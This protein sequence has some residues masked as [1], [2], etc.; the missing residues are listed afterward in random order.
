MI[1]SRRLGC[2]VCGREEGPERLFFSAKR[3]ETNACQSGCPAS[4]WH[5]NTVSSSCLYAVQGLPN[6]VTF[7]QWYDL[8]LKCCG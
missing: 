3:G 1:I 8:V 2:V 7:W 4:R 6:D 5:K